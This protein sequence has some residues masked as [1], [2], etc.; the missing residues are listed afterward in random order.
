[1]SESELPPEL[2]DDEA[3]QAETMEVAEE[4]LV[5]R[6]DL[7]T[8]QK[9]VESIEKGLAMSLWIAMCG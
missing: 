5:D 2:N 7:E 4:N 1:M 3:D 9:L 6:G 8:V